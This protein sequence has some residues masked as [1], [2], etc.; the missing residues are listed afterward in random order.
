LNSSRVLA[1]VPFLAEL[2]PEE[3]EQ[4]SKCLRRRRYRKG[5]VIFLEGDPGT[6]L[7]LI[8]AGRVK[9]AVTSPQGREV[10]LA[11][12]GPGDFFGELS[13]LDDEPRSADA[14]AHEPCDLLLLQR[15]DFVRFLEARPKAAVRLLAAVSRRL[16]HTTEQVQDVA[17]LDVPGRLARVLLDLAESQGQPRDEGLVLPARLT[18]AELAGLVGAT[19][20]SVN[21]WLGFYE[22]QGLLRRGRDHITVTRPQQLRK[23]IY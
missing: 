10:I 9:I 21:K 8:E 12:R 15:S 13:L 2:S 4:L 19:R 16:R 5:E 17:S 7:Y 3:V 11:L 18:Q 6:T 1:Q 14:A 20:E 22:R 23:R